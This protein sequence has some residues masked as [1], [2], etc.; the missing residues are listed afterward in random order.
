MGA[1]GEARMRQSHARLP[2]LGLILAIGL[3]ARGGATTAGDGSVSGVY[4]AGGK[5]ETIVAVTAHADEPFAGQPQR[6]LS[7]GGNSRSGPP[8]RHAPPR[9][10]RRRS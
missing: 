9:R 10:S 4:V 7:L 8:P 3:G 5:A 6:A 1:D 2:A